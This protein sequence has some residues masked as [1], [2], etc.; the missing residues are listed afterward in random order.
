MK[1]LAPI[2]IAIILIICILHENKKKAIS[3]IYTDNVEGRAIYSVVFSDGKVMDGLYAEEVS[4]GLKTNNWV[5]D[6]DL[7]LPK[8]PLVSL[9]ELD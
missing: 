8:I 5:Y 2:F 3:V 1:L 7:A 4:N 9:K 6:E